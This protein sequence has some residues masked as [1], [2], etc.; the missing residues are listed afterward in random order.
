QEHCQYGG[1]LREHRRYCIALALRERLLHGERK[2]E[3]EREEEH[4]P[5]ERAIPVVL[6]RRERS[7]HEEAARDDADRA[8]DEPRVGRFGHVRDALTAE[9]RAEK[10]QAHDEDAA[11]DDGERDEMYALNHRE[12]VQRIVD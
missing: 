6:R 7:E 4:L 2:D 8:R 10:T 12:R 5:P 3:R 11:A 9:A 1:A